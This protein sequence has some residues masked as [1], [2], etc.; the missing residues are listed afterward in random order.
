[1]DIVATARRIAD[2]VL[3][4][5]ALA[6]DTA[7]TLPRELLDTLADAGLYGIAAPADAGGLDADFATMCAVAELLASG[8]LTTAFV[9]MQH[10]G[11]VRAIGASD[12]QELREKWLAPLAA[13]QVR[14]GFGGGG[15]LPRPTLRALP[16]DQGAQGGGWRLDGTCAFVSGWGRVDVVHVS[17]RTPDDQVI[18]FIVDAADLGDGTPVA[19]AA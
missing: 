19:R 1:M 7:D 14:A 16:D 18:W 8:C 2:D 10:H 12:R 9:W 5:A 17:A 11:L 15:A 6:T 13:G 3:F 4:P